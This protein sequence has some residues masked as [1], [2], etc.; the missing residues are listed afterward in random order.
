MLLVG[1]LMLAVVLHA[2]DLPLTN[3]AIQRFEAGDLSAAREAVDNAVRSSDEQHHPYT[4]FVKGFIY[5]EL[6]KEIEKQNPF[7]ENREVAVQAIHRSMMLDEAGDYTDNNRKALKYLALSYYNDAVRFTRDLN[8]QTFNE[9]ERFYERYRELYQE[10][11][12]DIDFTAQDTEFYKNMARSCRLLW[13]DD[14][15]ENAVY[16]EQMIAFYKKTLI[17]DPQDFQANY[18]L[19]VNYYNKGVF[20]IRSI[21]HS[22][23]LFELMEIQDNCVELFRMALPFMERAHELNPTHQNTIKGLMAIHRS[24]SEDEMAQNYQAQLED[25]IRSKGDD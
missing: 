22:T 17:I 2:Q 12:P 5:K 1:S 10:V 8:D 4:W 21:D 18:N 13:Q 16:F 25:L 20:K 9:P 14:R 3:K 6:F 19:A 15:Q 24:L 7:S 11:D 23:E